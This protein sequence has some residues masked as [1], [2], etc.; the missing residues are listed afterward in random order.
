MINKFS[1]RQLGGFRKIL[2]LGWSL[3]I[4]LSFYDPVSLWLTHPDNLDSPFH[5][6]PSVCILVQGECWEHVNFVRTNE[7]NNR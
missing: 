4:L 1:E 2:A 3:L 7:L 6:D 5:I